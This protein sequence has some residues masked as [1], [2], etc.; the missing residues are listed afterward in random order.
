[1]SIS[2]QDFFRPLELH[3]EPSPEEYKEIEAFK[4][5]AR[6]YTHLTYQSVYIID[7]YKRGFVYVSENP[8]FLCGHAAEE[9]KEAGYLF[10]LNNVP[11][12]DLELLL[13]IN[14]AGFE[15]YKTI[16]V[17][18]RLD[19]V[20]TYDFQL[21][22]SH[23]NRTSLINH[24]LTPLVLD[25]EANI[26]LALCVVSP[27]SNNRSGNIIIRKQGENKF[28]QYNMETK[29]WEEKTAVVL[30][31]QERDILILTVQGYTMQEIAERL[32]VTIDTIKF[33]KKQLFRK[34]HARNIS[35]AIQAAA[36]YNII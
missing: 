22:Q 33:H 2:V 20:I 29:N 14:E 8:L 31:S 13:E 18:D 4:K 25:K 21:N 15:F 26:W 12:E 16:P 28:Y 10:Y 5:L 11:E 35:E 1:M 32:F 36:N 6:A 27:A 34:L 7:Y 3:N 9:V 24:K 17:E 23:N 30:T 19:Y